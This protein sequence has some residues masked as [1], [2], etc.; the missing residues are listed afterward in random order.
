MKAKG[1]IIPGLAE[2]SGQRKNGNEGV[3]VE[4]NESTNN[5]VKNN[6]AH[7][8]TGNDSCMCHVQTREIVADSRMDIFLQVKRLAGSYSS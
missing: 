1:Q 4:K 7:L 8:C 2:H 6:C 3:Y 5:K